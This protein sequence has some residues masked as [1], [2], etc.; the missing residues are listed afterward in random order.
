MTVVDAGLLFLLVLFALRGFWR[1]FLRETL[2]LAGL[3]LAG[4]LVVRWSEP[5]AG[6]VVARAGLS[7][8]MARLISAVGLALL[9]F[10]VVRVL[11]A[12]VARLT[13]ALFLR[14]IDRVAGVG[15]GLA[16]GTALLGL[17]LATVL[18]VVAPTSDVSHMIA[19]SRVAQPLLHVADRIVEAARPLAEATRNTI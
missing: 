3:A 11:G 14:P 15:L 6:V 10:L 18:R 17:G 12:L 9:V 4:V 5:L 8:L 1:G 19:A 16:E 2:G 7:P 13:S